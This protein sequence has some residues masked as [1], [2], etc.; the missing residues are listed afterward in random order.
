MWPAWRDVSKRV[1]VYKASHAETTTR[2]EF[3]RVLD[4][5]NVDVDELTKRILTDGQSAG[6][7]I[8][9]CLLKPTA[10]I[11]CWYRMGS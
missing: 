5:L 8:R 6:C 11:L 10:I 3:C 4:H 1:V 9:E 2:R 7:G